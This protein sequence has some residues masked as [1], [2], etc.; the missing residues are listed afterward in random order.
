MIKY[1]KYYFYLIM[2]LD[3]EKN[4]E[5]LKKVKDNIY[6]NLMLLNRDFPEKSDIIG[7]YYQYFQGQ[8]FLDIKDILNNFI[9]FLDM[10]LL[11][12]LLI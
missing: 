2:E 5:G 10:H 7:A 1:T 8:D 4:I 6:F 9:S 3:L 12:K 11:I